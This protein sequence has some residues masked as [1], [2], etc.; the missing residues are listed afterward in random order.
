MGIVGRKR[1]NLEDAS[2]GG[3]EVDTRIRGQWAVA[4]SAVLLSIVAHGLMAW[5]ASRVDFSLLAWK[6]MEKPARRFDAMVVDRV[7]VAVD[8]APVLEALRALD[9]MGTG[10]GD[11][12]ANLEALQ[13]PPV[14]AA[15]EPPALRAPAALPDFEAPSEMA[16]PPLAATWQPRQEIL[17]VETRA[18]T[19]PDLPLP[20]R[21]IPA[22][23]RALV[24]PDIT[25][26]IDVADIFVRAEMSTRLTVPTL[27]EIGDGHG[28]F[29]L[30]G[31]LLE[32]G[33]S[34]VSI[35]A[36]GDPELFEERPDEITDAAPIETVLAARVETFIRPGE[37]H[38]YFRLT[39]AR[40]GA[41][42]LPTMPKD[43]LLVQD[44]SATIA[45]RRLHFSREG[46]RRGFAHIGPQDRLNVAKFVERTTYAF[47][48]WV[49]RNTENDGIARQF[50]AAMQAEGN[51]DF[52]T[53]MRD[54]LALETDPDR[55]VIAIVVT[56]GLMHSGI[57][58]STEVIARFTREN[59]GRISI[60]TLGVADYANKYLL[61]MLSH[62]NMGEARVVRAGRW[63]IPDDLYAIIRSVSRPVLGDLRV[64][65]GSGAGIEGYP[66][67]PGNLYLDRP[68]VLYG[69]FARTEER[70]VFHAAGRAGV[71]RS[72]MVFDLPLVLAGD[73]VGDAT[74][75]DGWSQQKMYRL[76]ALY[77]QTRDRAYLREMRDIAR[78]YGQTVPFRTI[79]GF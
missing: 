7:D 28:R 27:A 72:D 6:E 62:F 20:R 71:Q 35:R 42:V 51:T 12:G 1:K 44:T 77:T 64:R 33:P 55:P 73:G 19:G 4:L 74:I 26:P 39:I 67:R 8:P 23:E 45:E 24:A 15:I 76:I 14:T 79:F 60:F 37:S 54:L 57:T 78:R 3:W 61:D 63:D 31:A 50:I 22:I 11:I 13:M 32:T 66:L 21:E 52:L 56:D 65:F 17:V 16:L 38:G 2:F 59:A 34:A 49:F 25:L 29:P 41:D 46:F 36:Q 68:L 70:L 10:V 30:P 47:P 75:R 43:I 40:A 69:R 5:L 53:S 18:V 58:D 48:D 9:A